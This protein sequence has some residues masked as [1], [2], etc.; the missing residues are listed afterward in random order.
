MRQYHLDQPPTAERY[1]Q[2]FRQLEA[3][4]K[5]TGMY[6]KILVLQYLR[7]NHTITATALAKELDIAVITVNGYYGRLGRWLAE[8]MNILPSKR[9]GGGYRWW[10][11]LSSG[12][13][14]D[15]HFQWEMYTELAQAIERLNIVGTTVI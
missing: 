7:P 4:G 13:T 12:D 10:C 11:V 5:L 3:D 14:E 8:R 15:G 1:F 9:E 2:A 6:R